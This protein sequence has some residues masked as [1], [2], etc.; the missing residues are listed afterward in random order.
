MFFDS[1]WMHHVQYKFKT[2]HA[3]CGENPELRVLFYRLAM[4]AERPIHAVFVADGPLRPPIKR[5][6]QV[7]TTPPWLTNGFRQLVEAFGF[8]WIEVRLFQSYT[9]VHVMI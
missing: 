7:K 6:K 4:L 2:G 3:Q 5:G 1:I 9:Y 8:A